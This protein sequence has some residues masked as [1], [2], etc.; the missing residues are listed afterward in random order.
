MKIIAAA[1][2]G[3][4]PGASLPLM[5]TDFPGIEAQSIVGMVAPA[6]TPP[7]IVA[8][9]ASDL[10]VVMFD[11]ELAPRLAEVGLEP[12]AADPEG[13]AALITAETARWRRVVRERGL[14]PI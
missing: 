13:F 8:K 10:R 5:K 6:G 2:E 14:T 3:P 7:A 9:I 1:S 12:V 11:P 4:V